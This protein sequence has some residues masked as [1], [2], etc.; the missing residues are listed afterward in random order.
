LIPAWRKT[1]NLK[2]LNP[3]HKIGHILFIIALLITQVQGNAQSAS[4]TIQKKVS[5]RYIDG[6]D[7][8][9]S[10]IDHKIR[11]KTTK[12]L[13]RFRRQEQKIIKKLSSTDS[14][15]AKQMA[16]EAEHRYASLNQQL[17]QKAGSLKNYIPTLDSLS[18][19]IAFLQNNP[20]LFENARQI[21][22]KLGTAS[23]KLKDLQ[24]QF[25]KA[26]D[27]KKFI[28]QRKQYFKEQLHNF[29]FARRLKKLNKEAYYYSAQL[30]E[31]KGLITDKTRLT[32]KTLELLGKTNLF[33]AFMRKHSQLAGLFRLPDPD[34]PALNVANLQG[35]QTRAQINALIQGQIAAGGPNAQAQFDQGLQ[36]AQAQL[37]QL[38]DKFLKL[39]E[40]NSN[41]DDIMPEGFK[42]NNQKTK[43]FLDRI[44]FGTNIQSQRGNSF[45]PVTT[46]I[47]LSAGYKI[48]D[49][50]VIG[51]GA[52][53]KLGWGENINNIKITHQG[54][55]LRSFIDWKIKGSLWIT[56]GYEWNYRPALQGGTISDPG[57]AI[58][59]LQSWQQSGL[60]GLSKQ[61]SLKT[62]LLKQTRVQL[63][64]DMLSYRQVPQVQPILFRVG[65]GIK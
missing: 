40:F 2:Y 49:K 51:V 26:E 27:V 11:R 14:N 30:N 25:Q 45:L 15:K 31:Y 39:P 3:L 38:K 13:E 37:N 34:E 50:S 61:V 21:N 5:T 4:D 64:W 16:V 8:Q 54:M 55:G 12:V 53:Y 19:S 56:G 41:P 63:L 52:S 1:I 24:D 29:G 9:A 32:K 44:E 36:D 60:L 33:K 48:N 17:Q 22:D 28:E 58:R 42:P 7:K 47:G 23:V 18:S 46:D 10:T 57:G 62:K 20:L 6:V 59:N 65:Y 35:L 43:S